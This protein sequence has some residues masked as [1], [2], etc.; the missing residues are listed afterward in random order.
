M[1]AKDYRVRLLIVS[2]ILLIYVLYYNG[3][4]L[5]RKYKIDSDF[6]TLK[7][8]VVLENDGEIVGYL[9]KGTKLYSTKVHDLRFL[10]MFDLNI[11]KVYVE[12][13]D[14][15]GKKLQY[16]EDGDGISILDAI[17]DNNGCGYVK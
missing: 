12:H 3:V 5:F 4:N 10:D 14:L 6:I 7:N 1:R 11:Y 8:N 9:K 16:T 13:K 2:M 17:I 15:N